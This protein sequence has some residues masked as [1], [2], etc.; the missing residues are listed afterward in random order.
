M[1][2]TIILF[3][4]NTVLCNGVIGKSLHVYLVSYGVRQIPPPPPKDK[5]SHAANYRT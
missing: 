5:S 3:I 4:D 2:E 1:C